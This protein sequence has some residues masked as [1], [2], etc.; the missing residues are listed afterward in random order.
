MAL[1][2]TWFQLWLFALG[3][4]LTEAV[5]AGWISRTNPCD[6]YENKTDV[7]F[8]CDKRRL[9]QV[10]S[11][12]SSNATIL[13]LS[14]NYIKNIS[15]RDFH[16]LHKLKRL[17]AGWLNKKQEVQ[18]PKGIFQNMT[19]L[20]Y[21]RLDGNCLRDVPE[22]LPPSLQALHL[23]RNKITKVTR[24]TF[25]GLTN[26]TYINLSKN[27]YYWMPCKENFYIQNDSFWNLT[28]LQFLDLSFNNLTNVPRKISHSV[29]VLRLSS[30]KIQHILENDFSGLTNLK[31]LFLQG[32]CPR[33][34]NAPYPCTPC[35]NGSIDIHSEAFRSLSELKTLQLS[36]NSLHCLKGSWFK[37]LPNLRRL[38]LSYNFLVDEIADGSFLNYLPH[39][40][41]MNL[42][43]NFNR[44]V[45]PSTLNLS[46]N[47]SKLVS[48]K[49]LHIAGYVFKGIHNESLYPLYNLK[50]LSLLN[51]GTNF[52]VQTDPGV[53]SRF[54][55][56]KLIYLSENR[57]Y[58][59]TSHAE[60]LNGIG[61]KSNDFF[62]LPAPLT[63]YQERKDFDFTAARLPVKPACYS[64][65][66]VLSLSSNNIFFISPKQFEGFSNISCLNLSNNGFTA[67]LNG[68]EFSSLPNLTYLD[69]SYNK[70]D[71]AYDNAFKELKK[72]KIL[73]LSYNPHYFSISGV[74]HNLN[75]M[76]NLPELKILNL[77]SNHIFTLTSKKMISNS[78]QELRFQENSLNKMWKDRD[79]SYFKI[80]KHLVNLT[81]L[82]LSYN[83]IDKIPFGVYENLP[84]TIIEL[85]LSH[86][87]LKTFEWDKL[88]WFKN[89]SILDLSHNH[90]T[91]V[92]G[93]I[94]A[95]TNTLRILNLNYNKISQLYGGFLRN[96]RSLQR[97]Y[98]GY[99]KLAV[100][101]QST[102]LS[103]PN[104]YLNKLFL[105]GNPFRCTCD[106]LEFILWLK[107]GDINIFHLATD[108]T[109]RIPDLLRGKAVVSFDIE[110]CVNNSEAFLIYF[111][112]YTFV[113]SFMVIAIMMHLFYWDASYILHYWR[114]KIQDY[115]YLGSTGNSYEAFITYDT[116]D[117]LVS[118]WVLNHL[119]IQLEDC[120]ETALPICLEER[121]WTPGSPVIDSLSQ[122]IRQSR[123]TIF[124]LTEAYVQSGIFKMA[125]YL[126]HQRLLD[127]NVDVIVLLL[128]EPVLQHSQ[129]LHLRR[130]LCR[131]TVLE[132]PRNPSAEPWFWQCLRNVIRVDNQSVYSKLYSRYFTARV[133]S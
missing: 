100:I 22:N 90:L 5:R 65:G 102:F 69:L 37:Y 94:S 42:N 116:K 129:F 110:Q 19:N 111:L 131:K 84:Q 38:H 78:L 96:A 32:N 73:D 7:I 60:A 77:S 112:C 31:E 88:I 91:H 45:Y 95:I 85:D 74:T 79:N 11:E 6:V 26:I 68:T 97:L 117:P 127:E 55:N 47:F 133:E 64:S 80:F 130:R 35:P 93:N 59:I 106:T 48:L 16:D 46:S 52:I 66:R 113:F 51:F 27:C 87:A 119:R 89:L 70:I 72:L 56:V 103:G 121:D 83:R 82:D 25:S 43:F 20:Y 15:T 118:D 99:N 49:Y 41:T 17:Y 34:Y 18:I 71:L 61:R 128:L 67:A 9:K 124:V 53:F 104:N 125:I 109:C 76:Q 120:G 44:M 108:V 3:F 13:F 57:L 12:I 4:L 126:A 30:N 33:C 21:L 63:Y 114:A 62:Q 40:Q 24:G 122:S 58:P 132:W 81:K 75:F 123:K 28:K 39:L 36:G 50:N 86:N 107:N 115:Q 14:E 8:H 98:L 10:P 105:E 29:E 92:S 23:T 2:L 1:F 101:N 54:P